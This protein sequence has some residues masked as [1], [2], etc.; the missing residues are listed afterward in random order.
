MAKLDDVR[1]RFPPRDAAA[2]EAAYADAVRADRLAVLVHRVRVAARLGEGELAA[3][4]G[5]DEDA[6]VRAEE[7]DP[8]VTVAYLDR[9][10]RATGVRM[11]VTAGDE[12]V[13]LGAPDGAPLGPASP[14]S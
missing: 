5:V 8:S 14:A 3:R 2:Y 7:G 6:I 9:L 4:M 1:R 11:T 10:A 13:V 12:T